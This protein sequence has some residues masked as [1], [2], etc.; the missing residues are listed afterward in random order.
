MHS[1]ETSSLN[2]SLFAP[3]ADREPRKKVAAKKGESVERGEKGGV[4]RHV[5]S[6]S[7]QC[8]ENLKDNSLPDNTCAIPI[9]ILI[10]VLALEAHFLGNN[11]KLGHTDR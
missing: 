10:S 5:A 3:A 7:G 9:V 8:I 1:S 6:M 4:T 2:H 11:K